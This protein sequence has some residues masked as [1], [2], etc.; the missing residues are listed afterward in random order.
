MLVC[1]CSLGA[2]Y[3]PTTHLWCPGVGRAAPTLLIWGCTQPPLKRWMI[4]SHSL[5][6]T[7]THWRYTGT[8]RV[9]T[10]V[11]YLCSVTVHVHGSP[12]VS[13]PPSAVQSQLGSAL[14]WKHV[15]ETHGLPALQYHTCHAVHAMCIF[16]A[17]DANIDWTLHSCRLGLTASGS[18]WRLRFSRSCSRLQT[19]PTQ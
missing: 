19:K 15:L 13:S 17:F 14:C 8:L 16:Q 3:Q 18:G 6:Q 2:L 7:D 9:L 1:L 10:T 11:L 5:T 12:I 4:C